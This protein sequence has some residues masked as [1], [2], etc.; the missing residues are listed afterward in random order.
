MRWLLVRRVAAG[1]H[2]GRR[3][4]SHLVSLWILSLLDVSCGPRAV[5][6]AAVLSVSNVAVRRVDTRVLVGAGGMVVAVR[7]K[8]RLHEVPKYIAL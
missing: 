3:S 5:V 7:L 1:V 4:S 6:L 2:V 8:M